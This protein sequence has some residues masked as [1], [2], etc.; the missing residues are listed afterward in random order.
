MIWA[1]IALGGV[2]C[3]TSRNKNHSWDTHGTLVNLYFIQTRSVIKL[4]HEENPSQSGCVI[5]T[6]GVYLLK[7]D[8]DESYVL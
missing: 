2:E 3:N 6:E 4:G 1:F 5:S 8:N 7:R